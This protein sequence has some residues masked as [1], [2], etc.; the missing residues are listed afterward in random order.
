MTA[1]EPSGTRSVDGRASEKLLD[2][3]RSE[4]GR[5]DSKAAV[6]MAALGLASSIHAALLV[7]RNWSPWQLST[8]G[9][10]LYWLGVAGLISALHSLL[11]AVRPRYSTGGWQP[12]MPLTHFA[13]VQRACALGLL[14]DS[15]PTTEHRQTSPALLIALAE[16]SRIAG[17]KH[18][19]I[20]LGVLSFTVATLLLPVALLIG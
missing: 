11:L 7:G 2:S 20:R 16:T 17:R 13:D 4:I 3:L 10:C 15:L 9:Q 8:A 14:A 6:L 12:G 1:A 18:H 5:A 19:W